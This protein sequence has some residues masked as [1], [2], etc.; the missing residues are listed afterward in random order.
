MTSHRAL[1]WL[2]AYGILFVAGV[3]AVCTGWIRIG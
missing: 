3:V 2:E 1:I